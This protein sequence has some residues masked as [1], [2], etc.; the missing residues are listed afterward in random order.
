M[1]K[2]HILSGKRML[3]GLA[4]AML[5]GAGAT[6][7]VAQEDPIAA[8]KA[9]FKQMAGALKAPGQML[10]GEA[11]L[12]LAKVKEGLAVVAANSAKL[13]GL[14]PDSSKTGDTGAL[15]KIWEDKADFTGRFD[16]LGKDAAAA[17]VSIKDMDSFRA[18]MPKVL[19]NC[20]AC[21]KI[22]RKPT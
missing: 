13:G 20:G 8:R 4:L 14:F 16:T 2:A 7:V 15:P 6:A 19:G 5:V 22:Y 18:A 3:C 10:K 21:H 11:P 17:I 12:D 9:L 1:T